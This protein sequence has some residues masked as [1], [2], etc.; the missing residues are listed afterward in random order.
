MVQN[1]LNCIPCCF[2][3]QKHHGL[4]IQLIKTR[5]QKNI[6]SWSKLIQAC[7]Q[8]DYVT[9]HK[10]DW[11]V[12]DNRNEYC[13]IIFN[14]LKAIQKYQIFASFHQPVFHGIVQCYKSHLKDIVPVQDFIL[15]KN[16]R[17]R[18]PVDQIC[19]TRNEKE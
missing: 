3:Y 13:D 1:R 5:L 18:K 12:F 2:P 8:N 16:L 4:I 19:Y 11:K 6:F 10:V 15:E 17:G 7:N 9:A 14:K